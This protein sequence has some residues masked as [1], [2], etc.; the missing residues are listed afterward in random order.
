MED[1][2]DKV[3]KKGIYALGGLLVLYALYIII[4]EVVL[5]GLF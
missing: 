4:K 2:I 5:K 1:K 3:I